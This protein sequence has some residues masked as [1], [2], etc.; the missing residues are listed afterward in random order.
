MGVYI[1]DFEREFTDRTL[2]ILDELGTGIEKY[3]VTLLI[4][5]CIG[6]ITLPNEYSKRNNSTF[7][8]FL[9]DKYNGIRVQD[10]LSTIEAGKGVIKIE[11]TIYKNILNVPYVDYLRKLRNA[12][13]H[14]RVE[15]SGE[16]NIISS[17]TLSDK[18][19]SY[20]TLEVEELKMISRNIAN[21]HLNF[22][23]YIKAKY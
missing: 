3:E 11:T 4:N 10:V 14:G 1:S 22:F 19:N 7:S 8:K 20:I 17:I 5:L 2:S 21:V 13:S 6:L 12:I 15:F 23:D 18:D 9:M 16:E